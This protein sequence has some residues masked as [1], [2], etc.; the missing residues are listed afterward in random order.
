MQQFKSHDF[1][2]ARAT[3]VTG[4]SQKLFQKTV[5]IEGLD[6]KVNAAELLGPCSGTAWAGRTGKYK[7]RAFPSLLQS[8]RAATGSAG[9]ES[10]D[11]KVVLAL[12]LPVT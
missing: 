9:R 2:P 11:E 6:C 3:L 1:G 12:R 4:H 5:A 10:L 7:H 8:L